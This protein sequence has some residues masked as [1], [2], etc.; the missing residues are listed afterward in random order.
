MGRSGGCGRFPRSTDR[1]AD[2]TRDRDRS[3]GV[4]SW[5]ASRTEGFPQTF[6]RGSAQES[7]SW[8]FATII[9]SAL[10][11]VLYEMGSL[12][13]AEGIVG[14]GLPSR[15]D[16]QQL[17]LGL[18]TRGL[19]TQRISGFHDFL[20]RRQDGSK[21]P[22]PRP[23]RPVRSVSG[24]TGICSEGAHSSGRAAVQPSSVRSLAVRALH[25]LAVRARLSTLEPF[26]RDD[27]FSQLSA[28]TKTIHR[29]RKSATRLCCPGG[30]RLRARCPRNH[31]RTG[32]HPLAS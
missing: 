19:A 23:L 24:T 29:D 12:R 2:A 31:S 13:H 6:A 4:P 22:I 10:D 8:T 20:C 1:Y 7:S 14:D 3:P 26:V 21:W 9:E 27:G 17:G 11:I 30:H 18:K 32:F 28:I 15:N 16:A 5:P 25:I